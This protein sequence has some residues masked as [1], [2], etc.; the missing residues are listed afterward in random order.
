[1]LIN[2]LAV[3]VDFISREAVMAAFYGVCPN[4]FIDD[5]VDRV[6]DSRRSRRQWI[7]CLASTFN[8]ELFGGN[9]VRIFEPRS[10]EHTSELQSLRQLVCRLLLENKKMI[11]REMA[12]IHCKMQ[13]T[14][15][16]RQTTIT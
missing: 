11:I 14:N 5:D 1:M 7:G 16:K 9:E 12:S 6:A 10:E 4:R 2:S 3:D 15:Y 13:H 8:S